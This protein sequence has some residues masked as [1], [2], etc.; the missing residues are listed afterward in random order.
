MRRRT[1]LA[2]AVALAPS[3]VQA[4][5][6]W[7]TRPVRLVVPFAPGGTTDLMARVAA[8]VMGN[9]LGQQVVIENKA[10]AGGILGA[11]SVAKSARD[12]Y[13][14]GVGTVSTHAIGP[15]VLRHPPYA[16][17]RDF[18]SIALLGTTP[19]AIFVHPS[20]GTTL[21]E[22]LVKVRA[23]P[24]QFH[25]GSPGSGS[26]GHLAGVWFNQLAATDLIH[27]PYRGSSLSLQ[28]LL[29]GR[30][31]VL[32]ENVPTAVTQVAAGTVNALA[33]TSTERVPTLS[34]TPTMAEAGIPAFQIRS[35]TM[36]FGPASLPREIVG[37]AND[38]AN[39]ALADGSVRQRLS[40]VSVD[41]QPT[42]PD[43][44][45]RFLRSEIDKWAPI[46]RRSGTVID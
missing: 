8:P 43:E 19:L 13:T 21:E 11:D 9:V 37:A 25:F 2:G 36:L 27:V 18:T 31:Q 16:P 5:A 34:R 1:A 24:G 17:D 42:S 14:L 45:S 7:P 46:V 39:R 26:L 28:D 6:R 12:G 3:F 20:M 38:A 4:Q 10:G 30:I 29:A 32:F 33:V 44:A 41:V 23:H 15:A 35:W 22:F 40:E